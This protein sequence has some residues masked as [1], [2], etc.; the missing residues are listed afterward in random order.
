MSIEAKV[1][2]SNK[3]MISKILA[4]TFGAKSFSVFGLDLPEIAE[5]L[6]TELPAIDATDRVVD[7]LFRLVDGSYVIVDFESEYRR[8]NKCKYLRY[9]SRVLDKYLPENREFCLRFLVIYTGDVRTAESD[10]STDCVTIHTE[11]AFLSHM[12]GEEEYK[13]IRN[14]IWKDRTVPDE[15]LMRLIV[16]PLTCRGMDRK[17]DM[18]DSVVEAAVHLEDKSQ[19]DFVLAG[20]CVASSKFMKQEQMDRIGGI[21]RMTEVGQYL[22]DQMTREVTEQVTERVTQQVTEQVTQQVRES[23]AIKM[24]AAGDDLQHIQEVTGLPMDRLK[25]LAG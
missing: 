15:D 18:I 16:L 7:R 25:I 11:Q 9:I 2:W 21:L 23:I 1:T 10:F 4:D 8:L 20:V 22:L 13:K 24:L 12:D 5:Y 17:T 14:K 6:P 19:R 3:D